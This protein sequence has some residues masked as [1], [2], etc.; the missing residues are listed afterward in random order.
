MK[1]EEGEDVLAAVQGKGGDN[2]VALACLPID[3]VVQDPDGWGAHGTG[4]GVEERA[5]RFV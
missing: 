3:M 2:E 1:A 4:E 5:L